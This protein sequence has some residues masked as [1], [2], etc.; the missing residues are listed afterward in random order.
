LTAQRDSAC[1]HPLG[2]LR[3][4]R[5]P[6]QPSPPL[7]LPAFTRTGTRPR[8]STR[9]HSAI[10]GHRCGHHFS[11][12]WAHTPACHRIL[13]TPGYA[14]TKGLRWGQSACPSLDPTPSKPPF[15]A[16]RMHAACMHTT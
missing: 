8:S 14:Q 7:Q 6:S 11:L 12:L 1:P 3:P 13:H 5:P 9:P 4:Q 2:P 15:S 16:R 10:P